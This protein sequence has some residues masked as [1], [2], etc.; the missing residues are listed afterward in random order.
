MTLSRSGSL[1]MEK[2]AD[3]R[4]R[5]KLAK[6]QGFAGGMEGIFFSIQNRD[7]LFQICC[8]ANDLIFNDI[9]NCRQLV[10][11]CQGHRGDVGRWA[12]RPF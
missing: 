6:E 1:E 8:V 7:A 3:A 2:F 10:R 11:D 5:F 12:I 4:Q 9:Y